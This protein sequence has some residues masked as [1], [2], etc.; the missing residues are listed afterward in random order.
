MSTILVIE[1]NQEVRENLAELLE[2]SGYSVRTAENGR[3]GVSS[4]MQD[5]PDLI[6]CDVMMPEMDGFGVLRILSQKRT[7]MDIPFI[8]LTAKTE[9]DDI[10]RGMG[11]GADDYITKPFDDVELLDIVEMRLKKSLRLKESFDGSKESLDLFFAEARTRKELEKLPENR[12]TRIFRRKDEI[13]REGQKANLIYFI[14]RGKVKLSKTNDL[15]KEYILNILNTGDFFGYL[16]VLQDKPYLESA[17]AFEDCELVIIP[18]QDFFL[19]LTQNRDFSV[20]FIRMLAN[21]VSETEEQLLN[22]AYNSVRKRVAQVLSKLYDNYADSSV[23]KFSILR[24]DLAGLAG[25][26]KETVIRTL[27]DFKQEKLID[28]KGS[29]ITI[30]DIDK[31]RNMPN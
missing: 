4:A 31:L 1:D 21:N 2:L 6:L 27:S 23:D 24:D 8:F 17:A 30:R 20:Q 13:Y 9:K 18:R 26:A 7:T 15:G 22:L 14:S 28:I 12:E 25:T 10:R 11:L 3:L 5:K 19:M 29:E 16:A